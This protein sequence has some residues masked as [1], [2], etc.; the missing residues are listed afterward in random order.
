[1]II[2]V[3]VFMVLLCVFRLIAEVVWEHNVSWAA[4]R[5]LLLCTGLTV[6]A[7]TVF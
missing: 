5:N 4:V 6:F 7:L 2:C 1:M 3:I